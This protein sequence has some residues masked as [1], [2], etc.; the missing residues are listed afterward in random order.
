MPWLMTLKRESIEDKEIVAMNSHGKTQ[1]GVN[2][3]LPDTIHSA[4][5]AHSQD[6]CIFNFSDVSDFGC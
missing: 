2:G 5:A 1:A 4:Y 3:I 6:I